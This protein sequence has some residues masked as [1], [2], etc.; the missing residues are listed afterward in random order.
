LDQELDFMMAGSILVNDL[1]SNLGSVV[2]AIMNILDSPEPS[3]Q[4]KR[5]LCEDFLQ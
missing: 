4:W 1:A 3:S 5:T 2:A